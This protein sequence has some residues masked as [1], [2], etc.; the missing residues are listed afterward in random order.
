MKVHKDEQMR[1]QLGHMASR[2]CFS[3]HRGILPEHMLHIQTDLLSEGKQQSTFRSGIPNHREST[4][5]QAF[6]AQ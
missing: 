2:D 3:T 1:F 6:P 5:N 4:I